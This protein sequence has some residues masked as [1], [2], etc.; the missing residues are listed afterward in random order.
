MPGGRILILL[1]LLLVSAND[2]DDSIVVAAAVVLILLIILLVLILAPI[3]VDVGHHLGGY[4]ARRSPAILGLHRCHFVAH[5]HYALV[6]RRL[7]LAMLLFGLKVGWVCVH[8]LRIDFIVLIV[9]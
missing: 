4:G 8:D 9:V 5:L 7:L 1:L 6:S 3:S 2:T